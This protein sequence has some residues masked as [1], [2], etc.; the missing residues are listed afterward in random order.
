MVGNPER[1]GHDKG[2]FLTCDYSSDALHEGDFFFRR[3]GRATKLLSF[4]DILAGEFARKI[5]QS[6]LNK[7]ITAATK[8]TTAF[9][10]APFQIA[11]G[12]ARVKTRIANNSK[13]RLILLVLKKQTSPDTLKTLN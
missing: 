3:C 12:V 1:E 2:F 10:P 7:R 8:L 4:L 6:N 11:R 13:S 9:W 5:V